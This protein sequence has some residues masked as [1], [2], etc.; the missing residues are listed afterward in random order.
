M[1]SVIAFLEAIGGS[2][3]WRLLVSLCLGV[4][5]S[6]AVFLFTLD[7]VIDREVAHT[8]DERLAARAATL[9]EDLATRQDGPLS[10]AHPAYGEPIY[11]EILDPSGRVVATSGFRGALRMPPGYRVG[12]PFN[13]TLPDGHPARAIASEVP[14]Y[15]SAGG[16][17]AGS[18]VVVA[19]DRSKTDELSSAIDFAIWVGFA[20]VLLICSAVALLAVRRSLRPLESLG[21]AA[22]HIPV[23][24]SPET[25]PLAG[26]PREILPLGEQFNRLLG[27]LRA[28]LDRERDFSENLAHELRTPLAEIRA[29][30]ETGRRG[31]S[32]E[33]LNASLEEAAAAAVRMQSV[34]ESLLALARASHQSAVDFAEPVD[35]AR[36]IR[37]SL[38][39][40]PRSL[41]AAPPVEDRLPRELWTIADPRL[42]EII[43]ANLLGNAFQHGAP[44]TPIRLE[45][46]QSDGRGSLRIRNAAPDLAASDLADL[47][48]RWWRPA[49]GRAA[50]ARTGS[51]L[52]LAIARSLCEA[53]RLELR[54]GLDSEQQLSVT[55]SGFREL[56]ATTPA[57]AT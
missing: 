24:E 7:S 43:I 29:L 54:F 27:R 48:K 53:A 44:G 23:D 4:G 32:L 42:L 39:E 47:G 12:R 50:R 45:W 40:R 25:L 36:L 20:I 55:L 10:L 30:S 31:T 16:R 34:T 14:A 11:F 1:A 9:I 22:A 37:R 57:G 49:A 46:L 6:L 56:G 28:A 3:R 38:S 35:L 21:L 15:N 19:E 41:D 52:G 8:L 13:V 26:M 51:G 33:E 5:L 2:L 17:S 18:V